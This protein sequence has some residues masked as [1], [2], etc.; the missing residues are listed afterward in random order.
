MEENIATKN[1][2]TFANEWDSKNED[3]ATNTSRKWRIR[4]D[5]PNYHG[6]SKR[7][8]PLHAGLPPHFWAEAVNTAVYLINRSPSIA[9][10]GNI[11]QE[12]WA[13]KKV[14]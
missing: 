14:N 5:E 7:S 13:G 12:A 8:M 10:D 11:P 1:S 6:A 9:F 3:T 4:E 2:I